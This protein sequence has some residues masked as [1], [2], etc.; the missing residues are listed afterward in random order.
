MRRPKNQITGGEDLFVGIP[1]HKNRLHVTIPTFE[2]L[3]QHSRDLGSICPE[4]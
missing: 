4:C 3:R 2:V 1:L